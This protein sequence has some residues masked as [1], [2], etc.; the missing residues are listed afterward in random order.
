MTHGLH[1]L[2]HVDNIVVLIDGVISETG[3]YNQLMSH[4]GAFAQLLKTYFVQEASA[5]EED[6]DDPE[7]NH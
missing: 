2:P 3:S 4:N 1:W 6:N 5:S 7:G